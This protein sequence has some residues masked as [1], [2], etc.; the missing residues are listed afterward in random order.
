MIRIRRGLDIPIEG[1]PEQ[2]IE[3]GADVGHVA[4]LGDDYVGM[5][6]H[7]AARLSHGK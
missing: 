6:V 1:Q 2:I 7:R 4:L 3:R 5:D